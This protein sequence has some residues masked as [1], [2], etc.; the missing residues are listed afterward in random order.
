MG[1]TL[2]SVFLIKYEQL[3][4]NKKNVKYSFYN[5][6]YWEIY[7]QESHKKVDLLPLTFPD[8]KH[9]KLF[10]SRDTSPA[11]L[12]IKPMRLVIKQN[13]T[14]LNKQQQNK[15]NNKMTNFTS[16]YL[17]NTFRNLVQKPT[18]RRWH[19]RISNI[20]NSFILETQLQLLNLQTKQ[21][22]AK[23]NKT[24]QNKAKQNKTKQNK[25]K[26]NKTKQ[27]KTKIPTTTKILMLQCLPE[28][29]SQESHKEAD[30]LQSTFPDRKH[31]K[32]FY[33]RD[34]SPTS[35]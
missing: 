18:S 28:K 30:L 8:Y 25:T 23:Q 10:Y 31:Q 19:S 2:F 27:N 11:S 32:L 34:T 22:K 20:E 4:T 5:V 16:F 7:S 1:T 15:N 3:Q 13:K 35:A 17:K 21:N 12:F 14:K 9:Q 6:S 33:S 29:Y 24:K 26:Q